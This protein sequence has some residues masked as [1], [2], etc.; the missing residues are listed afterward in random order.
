MKFDRYHGPGECS[1]DLAAPG[2]V[3]LVALRG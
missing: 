1:T 3:A 2:V